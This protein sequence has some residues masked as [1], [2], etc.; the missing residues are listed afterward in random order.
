[1]PALVVGLALQGFQG[2][3]SGLVFSL[4]GAAAGAAL[5]IVPFSM[6]WVG[7]GDLKLLAAIGALMGVSFT[8]RTLLLASASAGVI[9]LG[10]LA[11]RG[12]L[13]ASLKYTFLRWLPSFLPS[14]K[15][16]ALSAA[17]PF[18]PALALGVLAAM[19]WP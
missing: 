15:P 7:G 1:M 10:W 18:G 5:L 9:T 14:T 11:I 12:S 19:L 8:F 17:I 13:A 6:G 2:G 16:A 3:T 4:T